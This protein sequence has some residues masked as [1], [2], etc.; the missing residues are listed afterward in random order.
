LVS[1]AQY[2]AM[3]EAVDTY[4]SKS[5]PLFLEDYTRLSIEDAC[6]ATQSGLDVEDLT[7]WANRTGKWEQVEVPKA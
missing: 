3:R 7:V 6:A 1:A 4:G 5:L 2:E